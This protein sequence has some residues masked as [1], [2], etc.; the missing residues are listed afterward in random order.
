MTYS[1]EKCIVVQRAGLTESVH[2]GHIAVVSDEGELLHALGHPQQP[3]FARSAAKPLQAIAV[4]E[5]GAKEA[6]NLTLAEIALLCASHNGESIHT[7]AVSALLAR[8]GEFESALTCGA[9]YPFH[10]GTM[11]TMLES[12]TPATSIHNNCSGKHA[13]ML[14]L[15]HRLNVSPYGYARLDHPVQQAMLRVVAQMAELSPADIPTGI[16]GCGVPVF[17]LPLNRLAL[18]Y[19]KLGT[20]DGAAAIIREA[21]AA[22]PEYLAGDDRYDTQLICITEGRV[23]GKMGAEGVFALCVPAKKIGVAIKIEDGNFRALYPAV[24][25]TLMQLNIIS[26]EEY[27]ALNNWH[28]PVLYNH[29][30]TEVGRIVPSFRLI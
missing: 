15:A 1:S 17:N 24:T 25:E 12:N 19:A 6:Y 10:K 21:L 26:N 27:M 28:D 13:G 22:H 2:R 20:L 4:L 11:Q 23:L 7:D 9:H 5:A 30:G 16:D 29:A 14:L 3:I 18:A 8:M